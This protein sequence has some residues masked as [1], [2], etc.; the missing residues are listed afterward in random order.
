MFLVAQ[1]VA[2]PAGEGINAFYHEHGDR[3]EWVWEPPSG[4]PDRD[5]GKIVNQTLQ[6]QGRGRVRSYLEIAAPYGTP[7]RQLYWATACRPAA[8]PCPRA[9]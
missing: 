9:G 8:R 1:R 2:T 4:I 7:A 5:P 3:P 6:V